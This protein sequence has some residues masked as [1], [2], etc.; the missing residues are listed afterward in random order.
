M[1]SCTA[2]R[3]P[4]QIEDP[5]LAGGDLLLQFLVAE[6]IEHLVEPVEV[7]L[8]L[9]DCGAG[10]E[11]D[12]DAFRPRHHF[13]CKPG[14]PERNA[15]IRLMRFLR[16]TLKI[17]LA[18]VCRVQR[19]VGVSGRTALTAFRCEIV[20]N[21]PREIAWEHFSRPMQWRSW[22][23]DTGAPTAVTP[24]EVVG[25]DT[26]AKF[27]DSFGFRMTQFAPPD[28]WMWSANA[29][30]LTLDYDHVFEPIS[31]RQTRMVFTWWSPD[32]ETTCSRA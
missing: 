2:V 23:G 12:L 1:R 4:E 32:S 5:N 17:F 7:D 30:W 10:E 15:S 21:V 27:G 28:H 24:S 25:P 18:A 16:R 20:V 11:V 13:K 8:P 26:V 14:R 22:L 9:A 6:G 29:G 31:D 19:L 3:W